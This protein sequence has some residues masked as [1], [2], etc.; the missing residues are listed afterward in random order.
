[1]PGCYVV[2]CLD[3]MIKNARMLCC[4]LPGCYDGSLYG[5]DTLTGQV[6]LQVRTG[7]PVKS[8]PC[9]DLVTGLIY[10]GSHDQSVRALSTDVSAVVSADA[11]TV[12]YYQPNVSTDL[13]T[14][15]YYLPNVSTAQVL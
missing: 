3:V 8:S 10:F 15:I 4:K 1:M 6:L 5:L 12:V 7:G 2:K 14:V 11:S 13:S 9:V